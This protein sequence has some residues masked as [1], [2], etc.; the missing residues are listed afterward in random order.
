VTAADVTAAD[1]TVAHLDEDK[2]AEE[3]VDSKEG[4]DHGVD[5][6]DVTVGEE[7]AVE[8]DV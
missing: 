5:V 8:R 1:V 2:E 7:G 4:V 6:T 3:N